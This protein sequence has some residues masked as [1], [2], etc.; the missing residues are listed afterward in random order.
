MSS[1]GEVTL[2]PG[3]CFISDC[4]GRPAKPSFFA[5]LP[6][7]ENSCCCFHFHTQPRVC[8]VPGSVRSSSDRRD[9]RVSGHGSNV[10]LEG[11]VCVFCHSQERP[12]NTA[13]M[14]TARSDDWFD[15]MGGSSVTVVRHS[16]CAHLL[17]DARTGGCVQ[18]LTQAVGAIT[19][20]CSAAHT[21]LMCGNTS[22]ST[23]ELTG[24]SGHTACG[25]EAA[26]ANEGQC[27]HGQNMPEA[28]M[29]QHAGNNIKEWGRGAKARCMHT[30]IAKWLMRH[31]R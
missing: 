13:C 4:C 31:T 16:I 10:I 6:E 30:T 18:R 20:C 19:H 1:L 28:G 9:R 2:P 21:T 17:Q 25:G 3:D 29:R 22:S 23:N 5:S 11:K 24:C 27:E 12:Y 14:L 7:R 15:R 8:T 26:R